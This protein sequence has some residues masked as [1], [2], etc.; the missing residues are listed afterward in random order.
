MKL[1]IMQPYFF[2]YLGYFQLVFAVDKFIFYDDVNYI[3][4]GWINRNN[5]IIKGEKKL[6]TMNLNGSSASKNIKDIVVGK[7]NDKLIKTVEQSYSKAPF[8]EPVFSIFREILILSS[9]NTPISKIA[10]QSVI[11][12]AEYL[13]IKTEFEYS[14]EKYSNTKGMKKAE[15]LIEICQ[16]NNA[17]DYVNTI[18]GI[19]L[20]SKLFFKKND[21][22]LFFIR[23]SIQEYKQFGQKFI[24]FLSIIDVLMFNSVDNIKSMLSK[25]TLI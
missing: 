23:N 15:R 17:M 18:G 7:Y 20:Y 2:P 14:S 10:G 1:A 13:D 3:K 21:I 16:R 24:P 19:N 22:N 4:G 8:F 6:I 5:I 25:Y 11:K 12:V 9:S